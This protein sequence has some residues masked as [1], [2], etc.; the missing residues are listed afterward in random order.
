MWGS[1]NS[2]ELLLQAAIIQLTA[3]VGSWIMLAVRVLL[4]PQQE[5]GGSPFTVGVS[6]LAIL[7]AARLVVK[8]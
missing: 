1:G 2:K 3:L 6:Q 5:G 7:A 8:R 4:Y